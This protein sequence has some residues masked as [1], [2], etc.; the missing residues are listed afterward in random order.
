MNVPPPGRASNR[1]ILRSLGLVLLAFVTGC[2][3]ASI[4]EATSDTTAPLG[5]PTTEAS[6]TTLPPSAQIGEAGSEPSVL[7]A[8]L[9]FLDSFEWDATGRRS[10]TPVATLSVL[11]FGAVA[12]DGQ[13]DT[14]A[15]NAA[16]AAAGEQARNGTATTIDIPAGRF[17]LNDTLRLQSSVVL[18]GAGRDATFIDLDLAGSDEE[19]ITMLGSPFGNGEWTNLTSDVAR[20]DKRIE[21]DGQTFQPG[22]V[23]E[24]EQD[25]IDEM[26]SR[27]EWVVEWGQ[28]SSGLVAMVADSGDNLVVLDHGVTDDFSVE[29]N[30]RVR[31]ISAITRAGVESM[32]IERIDS[33]YGHIIAMRFGY[34]LWV[35][36]VETI[37]ASRAHIGIDVVGRCEVTGSN[38]HGAHD[39]GDGG[40]AYGISIARHT[41]NC[42]IEDN[43]L[44]DLRHAMI[45]QLGASGN[46]FGYNDARGSAGYEDRQPRADI[47]LHGHWP[48]AN[49]FEGN[50]VDRV[51][52]A[53][54]WG[55]VGPTNVFWRGC[56]L[57][58][59]SVI[60]SSDDQVIVG[61]VLGDLAVEDG[62]ERTLLAGNVVD[63]EAIDDSIV[64]DGDPL[65]NSLYG[66]EM[67]LPTVANC[68]N[69]ASERNPWSNP[70]IDRP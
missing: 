62:I 26:V 57:D 46:V 41:T 65:P 15:F 13:P 4:G 16:V 31:P 52:F 5:F 45:I 68:L 1:R 28:G 11:D 32:T 17:I 3:G 64:T 24:I 18:R 58:S 61:S 59:V 49:L 2:S 66:A 37:R 9:A 27:D 19:G 55:P 34:D 50:V 70:D 53:D 44:W 40:R 29:R 8:D 48:Q 35:N 60:E 54:W 12:D 23:L 7:P 51:V 39:F 30:A 42:L 21:F 20:G 63:G 47:S 43:A 67:Q 10:E 6:T 33:G 36:D 22:Q 56:A 25:N 14:D 38:L 69:G